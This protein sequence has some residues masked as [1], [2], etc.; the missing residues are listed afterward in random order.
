M[1]KDHFVTYE[2][3]EHNQH[4]TMTLLPQ[5]RRH[6]KHLWKNNLIAGLKLKIFHLK[7]K[8]IIFSGTAWLRETQWK[9]VKL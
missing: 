9:C 1:Q 2:I 8:R 6:F 7:I 3:C 5:S 4:S